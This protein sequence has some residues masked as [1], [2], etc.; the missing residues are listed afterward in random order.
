[1]NKEKK[2]DKRKNPFL[3]GGEVSG[4]GSAITHPGSL[5][6]EASMIMSILLPVIFIFLQMTLFQMDALRMDALITEDSTY[7]H[8]EEEDRNTWYSNQVGGFVFLKGSGIQRKAGKKK[9]EITYEQPGIAL[10]FHR[11]EDIRKYVEREVRNPVKFL[12][13]IRMI[14]DMGE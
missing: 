2:I 10:G 8:L 7:T 9:T 6:V 3:S 13:R 1:M 11:R 5:T 4:R 14:T 12:R